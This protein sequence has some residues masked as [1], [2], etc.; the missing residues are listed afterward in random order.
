M[1]WG[2]EHGQGVQTSIS[3]Q[4]LVA[5]AAWAAAPSACNSCFIPPC[6][7]PQVGKAYATRAS[8]A[9]NKKDALALQEEGLERLAAV[10]ARGSHAGGRRGRVG[11]AQLCGWAAGAGGAQAQ[12]CGRRRHAE[13]GGRRCSRPV[14]CLGLTT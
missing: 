1:S 5:H 6:C 8:R 14:A 2:Q 3:P 11:G 9:A 4:R 10:F 7:R 13:G 12:L